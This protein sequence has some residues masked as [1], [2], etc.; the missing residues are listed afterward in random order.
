MQE[1]LLTHFISMIGYM[2]IQEMIFLDID[3]YNNMKYRQE[4]TECTQK[5]SKSPF[6]N[7]NENR[8]KTTKLN[9][10]VT[11]S[12]KRLTSAAAEPQPE[13]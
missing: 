3:V 5:K 6:T 1:V 12:L 9:M 13:A 2:A 4:L 10:P 11:E 8:L 7:C